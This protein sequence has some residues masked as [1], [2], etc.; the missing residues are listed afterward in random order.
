M[1]TSGAQLTPAEAVRSSDTEVS[2]GDA[3]GCRQ[4]GVT[5]C[6]PCTEP[7]VPA[8][9]KSGAVQT[10]CWQLTPAEALPSSDV[11]V[12]LGNTDGSRQGG[13]TCC[14]QGKE[15]SLPAVGQGVG[16]LRQGGVA[17]CA[18]DTEPSVPSVGN[19]VGALNSSIDT[20]LEVALF[21]VAVPR[22]WLRSE[23]SWLPVLDSLLRVQ[24][25]LV[26][27]SGGKDVCPSVGG[28]ISSA[29]TT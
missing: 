25:D 7:S 3:V 18:K 14:S 28:D 6:A 24:G 20:S 22:S 11:E 8:V 1:R 9:G 13:V 19:G 16:T 27:V 10:S 15:P 26:E 29:R 5:C 17:C 12:S 23:V 2:L 4:G 21:G